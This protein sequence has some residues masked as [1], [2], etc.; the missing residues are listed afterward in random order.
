[1]R[2]KLII[3]NDGCLFYPIHAFDDFYVDISIF[4]NDS[5]NTVQ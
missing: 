4:C 2:N 3:G 1:M 5:I